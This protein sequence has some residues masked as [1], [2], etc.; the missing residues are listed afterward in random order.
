MQEYIMKKISE[1]KNMNALFFNKIDSV[2]RSKEEEFL[3][4]SEKI[5]PEFIGDDKVR[6]YFNSLGFRS[7]EFLENHTGKHVLFAGCSETE[8]FGG[9][10]EDCW[11]HMVYTELCKKEKISG[12][13]NLSRA[14]WGNEIIIANIIQYISRYGK[15]D[16]IYMLLP[17]LSRMFEYVGQEE[18]L[19]TYRHTQLTPYWSQKEVK[20]NDGE[21]RK[22][23]TLEHQRNMIPSFLIL[24]KLFEEY[25]MSNNIKLVWGTWAQEDGANYKNLNV[26]NSFIK[27]PDHADVLLKSK[28]FL[29]KDKEKRKHLLKKRDGHHGYLYHYMWAQSFLGLL[30]TKQ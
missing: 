15:P 29:P 14:G 19:E 23:Q 9:N 5:L 3:I 26:F 25:C 18:N 2:V 6:Y 17:N 13:F 30:D 10:L 4:N 1:S 16:K 27:L 28:N 22:R 7:D 8:G 11:S 21:K 20:G 12:F 24:M